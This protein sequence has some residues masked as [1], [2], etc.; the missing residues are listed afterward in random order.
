MEALAGRVRTV[1]GQRDKSAGGAGQGAPKGDGGSSAFFRAVVEGAFLVA[2]ADDD[3]SK[4]EAALLR[5][6]IAFVTGETLGPERFEE[7]IDELMRARDRDGV[8]GRLKAMA[9]AV[10]GPSE[11][12]EVLRFAAAIGLC[13]DDLV[14]RERGTL[15]KMGRSLGVGAEEVQSIVDEVRTSL[16][17][18]GG[19]GQER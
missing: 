4:G 2:A 12:R 13:D 7:M 17:G 16:G 5:E 14:L 18:E 15:L 9:R 1:F 19:G 11:R 10:A 3:L 8:E 6:T